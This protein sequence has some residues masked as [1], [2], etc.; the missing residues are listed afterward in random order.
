MESRISIL[1]WL[2]PLRVFVSITVFC[3]F[4]FI[5]LAPIS[6][7]PVAMIDIFLYP[8]FTQ[9]FI[10]FLHEFTFAGVGFLAILLLTFLFGRFYCSTLCPLGT[11]MDLIIKA[12]KIWG[13][14]KAHNYHKS[15]AWIPYLWVVIITVVIISGNVLLF[16]L[17]DPFSLSGKIVVHMRPEP[18][19]FSKPVF[20]FVLVFL[21]FLTILTLYKDRRYCDILC[22]IG[23][24]LGVVASCSLFKIRINEQSCNRC[25]KCLDVCKAGCIN[26]ESKRVEFYR[27]VECFNCFKSCQEGAIFFISG[28]RKDQKNTLNKPSTAD[29]RNF[30]RILIAGTGFILGLNKLC[31][32]NNQEENLEYSPVMPPGAGD[33][34]RFSERCT[35]CHLCI[36]SCPTGV[37]RPGFLDYG[38][39]GIFQPKMD[40]RSGFCQHQCNR[41]LTVC[42]TG[43]IQMLDL[44]QKQKLQ[45]GVAVWIRNQCIVVSSRKGCGMCAKRCPTDAL[46]MVSWLGGLMIPSI[47]ESRC[48]GCGV[49]EYDCPV[50]PEKAI[51][52]EA[53]KVQREI[54]LISGE[55]IHT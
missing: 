35:A 19:S 28:Y 14:K 41:C 10:K 2:K 11:L 34:D 9:S 20:L 47:D 18:E 17:L 23:G 53:N 30:L 46:K 49:C 51:F 3:F 7:V 21:V 32:G 6:L 36:A 50:R 1:L 48:I 26:L 38:W 24:I 5:Y 37:L 39:T 13:I 29:R 33:Q 4:L 15:V 45:I 25:G 54:R 40:F 22:P 16:G 27:C 44:T 12:G 8:Q 43:A 42:P 31:G 52:V 55:I